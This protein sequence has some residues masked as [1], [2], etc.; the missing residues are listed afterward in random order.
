MSDSASMRPRT[1][2]YNPAFLDDEDLVRG[3]VVREVD[4]QI[5]LEA[6]RDNVAA[7]NSHVLVVGPRGS[8]KTSLL[9]RVVIS[10]SREPE[11]ERGW[12][13]I[14]FAEE[15]YQVASVGELW[16]EALFHLAEQTDDAQLRRSH[17][18]LNREQDDR[19]LRDRS[20]AQLL[21]YA[22]AHDRRL[23]LVIENFHMLIDQI[24]D[25]DAWA[26]RHTLQNEPRVMLLA[27]ATNR[28][29]AIDKADKALYEIFH[30]HDLRPLSLDECYTV[31]SAV[32]GQD[33]AREQVRPLQ[34]LTGGNLR[35][36]TII[37]RF[38]AAHSFPALMAELMSLV[39]EHTEYFKS[40]LDGMAMTERK[41]YLALAEAWAP[42][43]AAD[44]AVA[45][46]VDVH[47]ASALLGRLVQ[48]GAVSVVGADGKKKLYQLTERLYNVYYLLR[49]RG[50]P[51]QRVRA[52][53]KFMVAYYGPSRF[54]VEA[55]G[56][57]SSE[58]MG[59]PGD[60]LARAWSRLSMLDER[61]ELITI[62][63]PIIDAAAHGRSAQTLALLTGSSSRLEFE[64]LTLALTLEAGQLA[65]PVPR[66]I[67]E[68]AADIRTEIEARRSARASI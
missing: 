1:V 56:T 53:V 34:I 26:I 28:F 46:R 15:S 36:M 41:V 21:D 50:M 33:T 5:V 13:P 58:A 42:T 37:S 40:H 52:V 38:G 27:S 54:A 66:E 60:V 62:I 67:A 30:V 16:L 9:R 12:L 48:R 64:A 68:M 14:V 11:L 7:P 45:A 55:Q 4:H 29:E 20:L 24:P 31:W 22:D 39:D 18:D 43:T 49:R 61:N 63:G 32:S 44:V 51:S 23:L 59:D 35:L 6:V 65:P 25:D 47:R 3:F 57:L 10:T 2:K 17:E 19:R 8:G